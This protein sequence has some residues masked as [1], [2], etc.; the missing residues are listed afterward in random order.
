MASV[1]LLITLCDQYQ[2]DSSV[3]LYNDSTKVQKLIN[4]P[5][6]ELKRFLEDDYDLLAEIRTILQRLCTCIY[7][8]STW[9]KGHY[10]GSNRE[11]QHDLNEAAHSLAVAA[12]PSPSQGF[13]CVAPPTSLIALSHHHSIT[14]NWQTI[15]RVKAHLAHLCKTICKQTS[16]TDAQF[17]MMDWEAMKICLQWMPWC[18]QLPHCKLLHGLL[19][20]N[21]QNNRY[22]QSPDLCPHWQKSAETFQHVV[23]CCHPDIQKHRDAQRLLLWRALDKLSTPAPIQ[24]SMKRGIQSYTLGIA[25]TF[26]PLTDDVATYHS[27]ESSSIH[28]SLSLVDEAYQSQTE[29]GWEYFLCGR[30][31]R[32]WKE[33]FHAET[34][35]KHRWEDKNLWAAKVI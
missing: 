23:L 34:L 29:L 10:K 33:V 6:R 15:L 17:E 3:I 9:V 7:F 32:Q 14:S 22:Y 2:I 26:A 18:C 19:N 8:S 31:S 13:H 11:I 27:K 28:N 21:V 1:F 24:D 25:E 4:H 5:G 12:L 20:T 16:W 35:A 30:L